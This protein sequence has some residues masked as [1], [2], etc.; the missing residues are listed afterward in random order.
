MDIGK[1]LD[2]RSVLR[3]DTRDLRLL[4]HELGDENAVR[5]IR[6]SPGQVVPPV[7]A[8]MRA[9]RFL[10]LSYPAGGE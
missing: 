7:R 5:I 4:Q 9:N 10:E 3:G 2:E 1:S 8:V 6:T